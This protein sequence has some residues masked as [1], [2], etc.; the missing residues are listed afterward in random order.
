[1]KGV[2]VEQVQVDEGGGW[3]WFTG[4]PWQ[5]W[6]TLFIGWMVVVML[7]LA[8]NRMPHDADLRVRDWEKRKKQTD[9]EDDWWAREYPLADE[10]EWENRH[11]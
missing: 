1:M 6:V 7:I 4:L 3:H 2:G 5:M 10:V 9:S 8:I 11:G